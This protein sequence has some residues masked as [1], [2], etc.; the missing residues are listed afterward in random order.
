MDG[1]R[2]YLKSASIRHIQIPQYETLT[3]K[4]MLGFLQQHRQVLQYL[5]IAKEVVK[6]PKQ[7]VANVIYTVV[8]D[9]FADWVKE[10]VEARNAKIVQVQNLAIDMDPD[11]YAAFANST[12]ISSKLL[13]IFFIFDI[14]TIFLVHAASKGVGADLCKVGSK[15]RRTRQEILDHREEER[16]KQEG[17]EGKLAQIDALT[18]RC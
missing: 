7:F 16:L 13:L 18:Q 12:A 8:G 10:R 3:L 5:P 1:T 14:I 15:R 2:K 9:P 11:V 6:L 4:E 17:M